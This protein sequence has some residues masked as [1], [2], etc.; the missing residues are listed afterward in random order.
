[1]F[2]HRRQLI[3]R[4]FY[5]AF[6][7]LA[8]YELF[9]FFLNGV[10]LQVLESVTLILEVIIFYSISVL[11]LKSVNL[12]RKMFSYITLV[13]SILSVGLIIKVSLLRRTLINLAFGDLNDIKHYINLF[14][15][16]SFDIAEFLLLCLPFLIVTFIRTRNSTVL[17]SFAFSLT[18]LVLTFSR[19]IYL[20]LFFFA[21]ICSC[22]LIIWGK[23]V[24]YNSF[25]EAIKV[26]VI[27]LV[28]IYPFRASVFTT[29][30]FI[31]TES[32]RLSLKSRLN[33]WGKT[34]ELAE[35]HF[36]LGGG[37]GSFS[38]TYLDRYGQYVKRPMNIYVQLL[39]EKGVVGLV[40]YL[41]FFLIMIS[42]CWLRIR[43]DRIY[44]F[45]LAGIV[46]VMVKEFTSTSM[47][48]CS[49][50]MFLLVFYCALI[51][52]R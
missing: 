48:Y 35:D 31:K 4:L 25:G 1:L 37:D 15:I 41:S 52:K 27:V 44:I 51:F 22:Y 23:S 18:A 24:I 33:T 38:G 14:H 39:L 6:S 8:L 3:D 9:R 5:C 10:N 20:A 26:A 49:L 21:F 2:D 40:I 12:R 36:F 28:I 16:P 45:L 13:A 42:G 19:G 30:N 32:Q 50:N 7:S 46:A 43:H 47:F 17:L 34:V 11:G 29:L